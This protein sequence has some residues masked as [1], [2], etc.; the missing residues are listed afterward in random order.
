MTFFCQC[1]SGAEGGGGVVVVCLFVC[2]NP[3]TEVA[4]LWDSPFL[5]TFLCQ[6]DGGGGGEGVVVVCLFVCFNPATE[7]V[8]FHL[9]G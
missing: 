3:A 9:C 7:V 4:T 1:D 8:T 5:M 6:Y 2:F